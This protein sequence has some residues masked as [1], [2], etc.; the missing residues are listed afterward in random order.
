[1]GLAAHA[2]SLPQSVISLA[3]QHTLAKA[4]ICLQRPPCLRQAV[5]RALPRKLYF[6]ASHKEEKRRSA[7]D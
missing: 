7:C 1:M 4:F 6:P 5:E 2:S 3:H